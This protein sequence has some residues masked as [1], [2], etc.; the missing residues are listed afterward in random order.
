[1]LCRQMCAGVS[2]DESV[3]DFV[4][5]VVQALQEA[6]V[7]QFCEGRPA[8]P[9]LTAQSSRDWLN[10]QRR[11]RQLSDNRQGLP[12][13]FADLFHA[14][15]QEHIDAAVAVVAVIQGF[16]WLRLKPLQIFGRGFAA[17]VHVMAG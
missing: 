16:N 5:P 7:D 12:R 11:E 9:H 3:T 10:A 2:M 4:A 17:F 15:P 1:M 14:A 6:I 8:L 13:L